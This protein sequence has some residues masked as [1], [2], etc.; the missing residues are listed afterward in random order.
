TSA[1]L[2]IT[3][4]AFLANAVF[5]NANPLRMDVLTSNLPVLARFQAGPLALAGLYV[6]DRVRNHE[7]FQDNLPAHYWLATILPLVGLAKVGA[8]YNHWMEFAASTAVLATIGMSS[9][10]GE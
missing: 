6:V 8:S 3:T 10:L 7:R 1:A 5:A 9:R 4:G 2:E